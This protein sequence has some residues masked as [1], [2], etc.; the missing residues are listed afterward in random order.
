MPTK[1]KPAKRRRHRKPYGTKARFVPKSLAIK[2]YNEVSTKTFYFK[3]NGTLVADGGGRINAAWLTQRRVDPPTG[4]PY[5]APPNVADFA[6]ISA[7]YNEYKILAVRVRLYPANVGT[8][9]ELPGISANPFNRG[10]AIMY[11]DQ[12]I[13]RGQQIP[14]EIL[15]VMNYGSAKMFLPRHGHTRVMYRPKGYPQ[16]GSVDNDTPP[17]LRKVDPWSGGLFLLLQGATP[18]GPPIFFYQNTYKIIFRGRSISPPIPNPNQFIDP[19][20]QLALL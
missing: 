7:C 17:N 19:V 15:T 8:E 2:R 12:T 11:T 9:S 16:W 20:E 18:N 5:L 6:R 3:T 10:N 4:A 13:E 1:K 14:T